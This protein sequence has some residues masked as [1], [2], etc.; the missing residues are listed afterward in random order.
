MIR[1]AICD[2]E[3]YFLEQLEAQATCFFKTAHTDVHICCFL[4]AEALLCAA[5]H[6]DIIIM[7]IKMA[8][9]NGMEATQRLRAKGERCQVIFVTSCKDYVFQAFDVNAVHYL[10][11]PVSE[12]NLH[13]ALE[14]ALSCC[15]QTDIQTITITKGVCVQKIAQR[16]ILY[17][18]AVDHK[19][20]I[21]TQSAR[22][23]YY[24]QLHSLQKLLDD[25]FFRCHRSYLV[26]MQ[27]VSGKQGDCAVMTNGDK[28]LVS[29]RQQQQFSQRLLS[30]IRREVL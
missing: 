12:Q 22:H 2:D 25:R 10:L 19:I 20:Y 18:E 7:D 26:N 14:K 17:C 4:S 13:R 5:A 6:F 28:V 30:S 11:K 24:G 8:G 16:D 9:L 1:M 27:Y 29:R 21:C 15:E 23:D 3:P